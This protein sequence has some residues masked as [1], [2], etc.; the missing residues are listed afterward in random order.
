[1]SVS[2]GGGS[3]VAT[4]YAY[5]GAERLQ[6]LSHTF[7]SPNA[8]NSETITLAYSSAN[9]ITSRISSNAGYNLTG[10]VAA[11]K[12]YTANG[13]NQLTA[14]GAHSYAFD[15]R[16]NLMTDTASGA[17]NTYGYDA[18]NNLTSVNSSATMSTDAQG[19]LAQINDLTGGNPSAASRA[20]RYFG[21]ALIAEY[22]VVG[23]DSGVLHQR[24]V[25]GVGT[26]ETV[27]SYPN[28]S[29]STRYWL[30][31]DE[32]GSVISLADNSGASYATNTY[33]DYGYPGASN[34]GR[35]Q[36][37]GQIWIPETGLYHYK[38]RDYSPSLG[39][40]MQ[41]DPI[42][43]GDGMNWYAYTHNDPINGTDPSGNA[44]V[45]VTGIRPS[46]CS[47]D[48]I[49]VT[50]FSPGDFGDVGFTG[51]ALG[52]VI[53]AIANEAKAIGGLGAQKPLCAQL[54]ADANTLG[55]QSNLASANSILG[56][57]AAAVL[58]DPQMEKEAIQ[59]GQMATYLDRASTALHAAA[60]G[61][62]MPALISLQAEMASAN[63]PEAAGARDMANF[64]L[65]T[66]AGAIYDLSK[67]EDGK[68][69]SA[70]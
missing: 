69:C 53:S 68:S 26:D 47:A 18:A 25:P 19:R 65:A 45:V 41:T 61:D 63:I 52:Q 62:A 1:M 36:Y 39:R 48:A 5:D 10:V 58:S 66:V 12:A 15:G 20:F 70:R 14:A 30:L 64:A 24:Y 40:F 21:S 3:G 11:S 54:E 34:G 35:F 46:G 7:P 23:S 42:G 57:A 2:R 60:T 49:C 33:D 38:A 9:Q 32:R 29:T 67:T 43:Y 6:S 13:Q 56:Q 4:S 16:G 37:T 31:T 51:G 44:D 55:Q 50:S 8:G 27:V 28:S 59:Y 17:T 22:G